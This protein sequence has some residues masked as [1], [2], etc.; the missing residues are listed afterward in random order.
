MSGSTLPDLQTAQA[1]TGAELSYVVQN[2]QDRQTTAGA[3]AA[4]AQTGVVPTSSLL[5]GTGGQLIGIG[6]SARFTINAGTLDLGTVITPGSVS[7]TLAL[8]FFAYNAYG[9]ITGAGST[10]LGSAALA[11]T[12]TAGATL[13]LLSAAVVQS[14]NQ[15]FTAGVEIGSPTGGMP[16]AGTLNAGRVLVNNVDVLTTLGTASGDLSGSYPG[17]T[18]AKIHGQ[19]LAATTP[20]TGNLLIANGSS[21]AS[22]GMTGDASIAATGIVTFPSIVADGTFGGTGSLISTVSLNNKG[23]V[24]AVTAAAAATGVS[25]ITAGAG[26]AA[27][28]TAGATIATTGTL[29]VFEFTNASTVTGYTLAASDQAKLIELSNASA[30]A[31][32]NPSLYAT[33]WWADLC[34]TNNSTSF[35]TPTSGLINNVASIVALKN[36]PTRIVFDG[37]NFFATP[38]SPWQLS[39]TGVTTTLTYGSA[40]IVNAGGNSVSGTGSG[41]L[42][43]GQN[44]STSASFASAF[45]TGGSSGGSASMVFGQSGTV[46][47]TNSIAMGNHATDDGETNTL[48]HGGSGTLGRAM[49]KRAVFSNTGSSTSA[50]RLTSDAGAAAV[51]NVGSLSSFASQAIRVEM[52]VFDFNTNGSTTWIGLHSDNLNWGQIAQTGTAVATTTLAAGFTWTQGPSIGTITNPGTPS[53]TADTT[54]GGINLAYTPGAG[55][56]HSMHITAL[57]ETLQAK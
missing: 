30:S 52:Q 1:L 53:I 20:T 45:G 37:T 56:T 43:V 16:G 40:L 9:Q 46:T 41:N 14:G 44:L 48:A 23:Q 19:P 4:L 12:G 5:G 49:Y 39:P 29:A 57:V 2:G 31:A 50:I 8:P 21:W 24:T 27:N 25:A 13:G 36:Q 18:V 22:V 51:T 32:L 55:N 11:A 10:T 42:L 33:G 26:I 38:S 7:G 54:L 6:I 17:P 15:Q 34:F 28:G 3:I 47:G 35:V